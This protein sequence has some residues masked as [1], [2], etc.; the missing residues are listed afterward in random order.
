MSG[1]NY[2]ESKTISRENLINF[3]GGC[4]CFRFCSWPFLEQKSRHLIG[5]DHILF[6]FKNSSQI[7]KKVKANR[8]ALIWVSDLDVF[9]WHLT[10][11]I[12]LFMGLSEMMAKCI[13]KPTPEE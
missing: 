9:I 13:L 2:N 4:H 5:L 6:C 11:C 8:L 10:A 1:S 3:S 12:V 7:I